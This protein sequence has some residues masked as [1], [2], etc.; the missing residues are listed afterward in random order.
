[1]ERPPT[2][3]TPRWRRTTALTASRRRP[4]SATALRRCCTSAQSL[5]RR[6]ARGFSFLV[7]F[8]AQSLS[9]LLVARAEEVAPGV[10]NLVQ[11]SAC[12]QEVLEWDWSLGSGYDVDVFLLCTSGKRRLR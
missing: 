1:M 2:A 6:K 3:A 4:S 12:V 5:D 7:L 9:C 8:P 11:I 10:D